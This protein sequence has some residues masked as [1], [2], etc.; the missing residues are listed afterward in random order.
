MSNNRHSFK[1]YS[2]LHHLA[3]PTS[4]GLYN[5]IPNG[6]RNDSVSM[7]WNGGRKGRGLTLAGLVTSEVTR[8]GDTQSRREGFVQ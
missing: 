1:G 7:D 2:A 4:S 6:T 8:A 3:R 5:S